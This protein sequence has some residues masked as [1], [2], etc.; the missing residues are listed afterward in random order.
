MYQS[1]IN[2]GAKIRLYRKKKM[3]SLGKLSQMTGIA[4]SN[5]SSIELNKTSPTLNTLAKI[6]DAFEVRIGELL[7]SMFYDKVLICGI[8]EP[9]SSRKKF[10]GV[11]ERHLTSDAILN[12][13]EVKSLDFAPGSGTISLPSEN[14]DRFLFVFK[15]ALILDIEDQHIELIEGQGAYLVAETGAALSNKGKIPAR[16]LIIYSNG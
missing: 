3:L 6:A 15:G 1:E 4:A 7:D 11:V 8:D 16:S 10:S 9:G 13:I 5:L 12:R 14:S 2:I